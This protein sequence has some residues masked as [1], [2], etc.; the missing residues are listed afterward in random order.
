MHMEPSH[1]T[2][3]D[4]L[5]DDGIISKHEHKYLIDKINKATH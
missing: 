3:I 5:L 2:N 4:M 1:Y